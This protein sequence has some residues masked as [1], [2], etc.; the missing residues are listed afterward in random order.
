VDGVI[1]ESVLGATS[2]FS[3]LESQLKKWEKTPVSM[4]VLIPLTSFQLYQLPNDF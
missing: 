2:L 3:N 1:A 4:N